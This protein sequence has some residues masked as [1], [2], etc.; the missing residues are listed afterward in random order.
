MKSLRVCLKGPSILFSE[1]GLERAFVAIA[2]GVCGARA[3]AH[4]EA[5]RGR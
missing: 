2:L 1:S 4:T 3:R 5:H